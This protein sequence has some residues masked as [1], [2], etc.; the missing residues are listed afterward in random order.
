MSRI[1]VG[2]LVEALEKAG[3]KRALPNSGHTGGKG[4]RHV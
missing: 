1:A 2:F 4:E 3:V